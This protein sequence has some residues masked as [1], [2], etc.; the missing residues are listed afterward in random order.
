MP[1]KKV[2]VFEYIDEKGLNLLCQ[3]E[4]L[5]VVYYNS[6]PV[7]ADVLQKDLAQAHG[8]LVRTA[9]I[10]KKIIDAAGRLEIIAKHGVGLDNIDI[11]AATAR[12]IPVTIT[13]GANSNAVAEHVL[14]M[15]MSLAK[16]LV[17]ADADMKQRRFERREHYFGEELDGKTLGIIGLGRIGSRLALKARLGFGMTVLTYDP[18][19]SDE[20]A[21]RFNARRVSDLDEL[22]QASDYVS[23]NVPLTELTADMIDRPELARMKSSAFLI[24]TSRGGVVEE[25][26]LYD[27]LKAD[28][29]RA[30]GL[31]VFALEPATPDNNPLLTLPNVLVTP[32]TAGVSKEAGIQMAVMSA[33]EIISVLHGRPPANPFNFA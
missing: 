7:P 25:T 4:L 31:D 29:I 19:V 8:I 20:Y 33:G 17:D 16:K 13:P 6:E 32:H 26:A 24:N 15:I 18:F 22:L 12:K 5:D 1:K 9:E 27:A 3:D 11:E 2:I 30:A 28:R 21:L 10:N 23:L 14:A